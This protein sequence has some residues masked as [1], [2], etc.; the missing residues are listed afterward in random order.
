MDGMDRRCNKVWNIRIV[1]E[2]NKVRVERFKL[3]KG[4]LKKNSGYCG[5]Q[6]AA[7]TGTTI[8]SFDVDTTITV[9]NVSSFKKTSCAHFDCQM[10]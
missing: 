10:P 1:F 3:T 5:I 9:L 7:A 2:E 6:Y 4:N 8:D